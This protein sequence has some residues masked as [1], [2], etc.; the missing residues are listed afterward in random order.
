MPNSYPPLAYKSLTANLSLPK[1]MARVWITTM[2]DLH[3]FFLECLQVSAALGKF[4]I[5][6]LTYLSLHMGKRVLVNA[7]LL[8]VFLLDYYLVKSPSYFL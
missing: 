5:Y 1:P 7:Y 2:L 6:C 3:L 4:W 8:S